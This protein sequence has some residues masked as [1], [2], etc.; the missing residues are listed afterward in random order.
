M[1]IIVPL[2]FEHID[3]VLLSFVAAE[4][5]TVRVTDHKA[6]TATVHIYMHMSNAGSLAVLLA[7]VKSNSLINCIRWKW[8]YSPIELKAGTKGCYCVPYALACMWLTYTTQIIYCL[9]KYVQVVIAENFRIIHFTSLAPFSLNKW[10]S[11]HTKYQISV[12]SH[13]RAVKS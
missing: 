6:L 10:G 13:H 8:W 3:S 2:I 5:S 9:Y 7:T 4:E 12:M 11:S 1:C